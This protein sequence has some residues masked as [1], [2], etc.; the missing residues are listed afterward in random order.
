M[1]VGGFREE[2]GK[3]PSNI[4]RRNDKPLE[5]KEFRAIVGGYSVL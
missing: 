2:W 5:L 1:V 4:V 3:A